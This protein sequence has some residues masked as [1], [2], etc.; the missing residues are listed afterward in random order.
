MRLSE[1]LTIAR[2]TA[3]NDAPAFTV[4]IASGFTPLHLNTFLT[5]RL[6]LALPQHRIELQS[7]IYG[8]LL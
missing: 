8:D 3:P 1:A 6:R 2:R 4:S 7:G 5:A